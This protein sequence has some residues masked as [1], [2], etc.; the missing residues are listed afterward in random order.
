MVISNCIFYNSSTDE[1]VIRVKSINS[2][3]R[4]CC[5]EQDVNK[6]EVRV[7]KFGPSVVDFSSHIEIIVGDLNQHFPSEER[8]LVSGT[9]TALSRSLQWCK[10]LP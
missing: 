6:A 10:P 2:V 1:S 8:E 9:E 7:T 4:C 5:L 3:A